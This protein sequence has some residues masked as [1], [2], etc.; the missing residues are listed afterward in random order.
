[1]YKIPFNRPPIV[2][3]E[4][5][6][7]SQ[8]I[9]NRHFAGDAEFTKKIDDWVEKMNQDFLLAQRRG[10]NINHGQINR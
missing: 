10:G 9:D 3:K 4:L 7:V 2:G 1:M 8:A 5:S 6:Y